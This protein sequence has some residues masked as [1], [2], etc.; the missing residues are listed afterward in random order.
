MSKHGQDAAALRGYIGSLRAIELRVQEIDGMLYD[1]GLTTAHTMRKPLITS[2]NLLEQL[3]NS[4]D[5]AAKALV[6]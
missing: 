1:E 5:Q 4:L 6:D 3:Q 2:L